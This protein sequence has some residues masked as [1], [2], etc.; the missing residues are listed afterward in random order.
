MS[1]VGIVSTVRVDN[2]EKKIVYGADCSIT[3]L[4]RNLLTREF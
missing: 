3:L 2:T 4:L 1:Q